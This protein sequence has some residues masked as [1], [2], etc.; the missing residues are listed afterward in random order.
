MISTN[1]SS[2]LLFAWRGRRKRKNHR[3]ACVL[4][5]TFMSGLM[6]MNHEAAAQEAARMAPGLT[7]NINGIPL[8]ERARYGQLVEALRHAIQKR[9]EL[10]DGYA[11]QMDTKH[12]S[13]DQL[14]EWI[15]LERKC[16][17]FFE[18]E[19]H[20]PPQ[21]GAVWLNL[22]GPEGVKD[23]ILDEFGLR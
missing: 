23:F 2:N 4:I 12:M 9:R 3:K 13:T 17:P 14:A 8:Q 18:F 1:D 6:L 16:C 21:D 5:T 15:E 10:P 11:F 22:S 19:M 7:C 20:W